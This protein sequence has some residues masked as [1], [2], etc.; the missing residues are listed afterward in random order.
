M[1]REVV[2]LVKYKGKEIQVRLVD[3]HTGH[4]GHVNFDDFRFHAEKPKFPARPKKEPPA[5]PDGRVQ[6]RRA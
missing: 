3:K 5:R 2:D 6:E 4:W 1:H